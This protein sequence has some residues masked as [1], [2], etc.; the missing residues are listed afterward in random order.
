MRM[1]FSFT[2]ATI[3]PIAPQSISPSSFFSVT[4]VRFPM[5]F[6]KIC[7][8]ISASVNGRCELAAIYWRCV[9]RSVSNFFVRSAFSSCN[10]TSCSIDRFSFSCSALARMRSLFASARRT[11][12][13]P[14][15]PPVHKNARVVSAV[16]CEKRVSLQ[17]PL[18]L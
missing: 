4:D 8:L 6:F 11:L 15:C 16:S 3:A 7:A 10:S 14:E 12:A 2:S 13:S 18:F 17:L 1:L 5:Y 9:F